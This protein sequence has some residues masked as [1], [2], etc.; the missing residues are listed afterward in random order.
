M[1]LICGRFYSTFLSFPG[2]WAG[3]LL[4]G[5]FAMMM[6]GPAAAQPAK[7]KLFE[8]YASHPT[9]AK[10]RATGYLTILSREKA[11]S[12]RIPAD[13]ALAIV[14]AV[15]KAG[16][17]KYRVADGLVR[18]Y[19]ARHTLGPSG[20]ML[21]KR[22]GA[23]KLGAR[24]S[25]ALGWVRVLEGNKKALTRTGTT[26]R[27]AGGLQ[28]L[29][30]AVAKEPAVQAHHLALAL[31]GAS[32]APK[33]GKKAC[34]AWVAVQKAARDGRKQ[35]VPVAMAERAV[36]SVAKLG[37]ACPKKK[38]RAFKKNISLPPP[39]AEKMP[40]SSNK[41]YSSPMVKDVYRK[42][43]AF[44][45]SAPIFK[46][47]MNKPKVR[48]LIRSKRLGELYLYMLMKA[49]KTGDTAI[50]AVNAALWSRRLDPTR[51]A[52]VT[53]RTILM[54]HDRK[55]TRKADDKGLLTSKLTPVQATVLGYARAIAGW[56]LERQEQPGNAPALL[57]LPR[58][59]FKHAH[60]K[61]P[62]NAKLGRIVPQLHTIDLQRQAS[63]CMAA[64]RA[65]SLAFAV[66]KSQLPKA[67]DRVLRDATDMVKSQCFA[68]K[69]A[70]KRVK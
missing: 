22:I 10:V 56:G 19:R 61:L 27:N 15:G 7:A 50:A 26:I 62:M 44:S 1:A 30:Q 2:A 24:E 16:A 3:P 45:V 63:L 17:T 53:W 37:K 51:I 58:Q 69:R 38:R 65:D 32:I 14:D 59:L 9:V 57:A 29:R 31:G 4:I 6:T 70:G 34:K 18:A 66:A 55:V 60:G 49:D 64:K 33:R 46:G 39:V 52:D 40:A 54:L 43:V 42:G 67:A 68:P 47:Y 13:R 41:D 23:D 35:A 5:L 25:L 28:L 48:D 20:A 21:N 11:L 8:G 36:K 12:R